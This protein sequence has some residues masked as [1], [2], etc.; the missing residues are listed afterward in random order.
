MELDIFEKEIKRINKKIEEI[1]SQKYISREM[2]DEKYYNLLLFNKGLQEKYFSL[3][4]NEFSDLMI[5]TYERIKEVIVEA[6]ILE[7]EEKNILFNSYLNNDCYK[8]NYNYDNVFVFI[9]DPNVKLAVK[10]YVK[11]YYEQVSLREYL[12][13]KVNKGKVKQKS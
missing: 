13:L 3:E 12:N 9:E 4:S 10:R 2:F 6:K 5:S 11:D 7:T 8:L 1:K